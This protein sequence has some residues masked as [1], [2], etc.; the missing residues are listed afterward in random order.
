MSD[1]KHTGTG[2]PAVPQSDR[3]NEHDKEIEELKNQIEEFKG[4][5]LRALADYQNLEKRILNER[6]MWV[7]SAHKKLM[8]KLLPFLDNL[9][10]AEVFV[11]DKS[12]NMITTSFRQILQQEGLKEIEVAGKEY[13]PY[14]AE[15]IDLVPGE[16]ENVVVEVIRK[17][18][19]FNGKILRIAQV[20]VSKKVTPEK[21]GN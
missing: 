1:N 11:K 21:K 17:G 7:Q 12:L 13:D 5:Y 8:E 9:D 14:V 18:Y 6:E 15:V 4:K 20:K 16:K 3:K 2:T 10:R 19:E